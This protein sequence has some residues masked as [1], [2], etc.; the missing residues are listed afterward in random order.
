MQLYT[1]THQDYCGIDLRARTMYLCIIS[2]DGE[3]VLHRNMKTS[4][5]NLLRVIEPYR[6]DLVISVECLFC[7]ALTPVSLYLLH[8]CSRRL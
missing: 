4:P 5:Q 2:H 3:I 8:P 1:K 7:S 6:E